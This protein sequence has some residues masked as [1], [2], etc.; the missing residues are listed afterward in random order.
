M[1]TVGLLNTFGRILF[2]S[3][4]LPSGQSFLDFGKN[5]LR[6]GLG[7]MMGQLRAPTLRLL[8]AFAVTLPLFFKMQKH[9]VSTWRKNRQRNRDE[10][11]DP[12]LQRGRATTLKERMTWGICPVCNAQPGEWCHAAAG[13]QLGRRVDGRPM[14]DGDGAHLQRLRRA[15]M[16]VQCIALP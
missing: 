11:I 2:L 8:I 10:M 12:E 4:F 13:F 7:H 9:T 6:S 1:Y 14:Q 3:A 16:R 5:A 15:P